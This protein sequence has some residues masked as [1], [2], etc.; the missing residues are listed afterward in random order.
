MWKYFF[1]F[2][3]VFAEISDYLNKNPDSDNKN[4]TKTI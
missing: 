1:W 4:G 2:H 3:F